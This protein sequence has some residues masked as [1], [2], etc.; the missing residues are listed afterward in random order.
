MNQNV[1]RILVAVLI[2]TI[3]VI[4]NKMGV[5]GNSTS[6]I[7]LDEIKKELALEQKWIM[8]ASGRSI[9][10]SKLD[11]SE[12]EVLFENVGKDG[13]RIV[14]LNCSLD[15]KKIIA[16]T[17]NFNL[18]SL[19]L[20]DLDEKSQS[21]IVLN[22]SKEIYQ[23]EISENGDFIVYD[24][25]DSAIL[26][27]TK[28]NKKI[29]L[30]ESQSNYQFRHPSISPD[31]SKIV[32]RSSDGSMWLRDLSSNQEKQIT[33][34]IDGE[35]W[36][37]A[38]CFDNITIITPR[39]V[40][41]T[42]YSLWTFNINTKDFRF[43]AEISEKSIWYGKVSKDFKAIAFTTGDNFY[44][45]INSKVIKL[46]LLPLM[47]SNEFNLDIELDGKY[48]IYSRTNSPVYLAKTDGSFNVELKSIINNSN[49]TFGIWANHPPYPP[50]VSAQAKSASNYLTWLPAKQGSYPI[51]G[52]NI[53]R[54]KFLEKD[55]TLL[56]STPSS[57]YQYA[58]TQCSLTENYYYLVRAI[59]EENIESIPSNEV[60]IDKTLP[61]IAF[62][63]PASGSWSKLKL[64]QIQGIARDLESGVDQVLIDGN[65]ALVKADGTF[66]FNYTLPAEGKTVITGIVSDKFGNTARS[67]LTIN[68]DTL[69][70]QINILSPTLKVF[71]SSKEIEIQ[72]S[73]LELGSGV[74]QITLNE[75]SLPLTQNN[76]YK[77][78]V[79][80]IEGRNELKITA[81]DKV[82]NQFETMSYIDLD[83]LPP[84]LDINFPQDNTE[85]YAIDTSARGKVSDTGS[86]LE[87]FTLNQQPV[88]L[89]QDGSFQVPIPILAGNNL[90]TF[91]A[92]DKMGN[93]SQKVIQV[94]G[95]QQIV[96][97]L[98]IGSNRIIVNNKEAT[99]DA[100]PQVHDKSKRTLVP[101]RFVVEPIGGNIT[102]NAKEQ[103]VTIQREENRIELWIGKNIAVVNGSKVP[104]D[105]SPL[106]TPM[107]ITGRT[108]LPLRFVSEN[109]GFKVDWDPIKHEIRLEFPDPDK[110]DLK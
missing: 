15:G 32:F 66:T 28:E 108:F 44:S 9:C 104:I 47:F 25:S 33:T 72:F 105:P 56:F 22:S 29:K 18:A 36:N 7:P 102:F 84:I 60:L 57:V 17:S 23:I 3:F 10:L 16:A 83:S 64:V 45:Y 26:F 99:I 79:K 107:I 46:N 63:S 93:T 41:K 96:V 14:D 70:P 71:T 27:L 81:E 4:P 68:L 103:K 1:K 94:K 74:K 62:T 53:Y 76:Q 77:H 55:Y 19:W 97:Q 75:Y 12:K 101:A 82:G 92:T 58:D 42:I 50:T 21:P 86:G 109:I 38:F 90:F 20:I 73:I 35:F 34:T 49:I 67:T 31:G 80:L 30:G 59:D 51:K 65:P 52:Y 2:F 85:L 87:S 54:R 11:G 40:K 48:L 78:K 61:T 8:Y 106:L 39:L 24:I 43:I 13:S 98:T 95:V 91:V 88:L 89:S 69:S 100:P 110:K 5:V 6:S 37:P